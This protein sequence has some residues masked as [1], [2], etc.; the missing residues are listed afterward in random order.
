MEKRI[1]GGKGSDL[2]KFF[3]KYLLGAVVRPYGD[4]LGGIITNAFF[5]S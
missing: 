1:V 2:E 4:I 5:K 3:E